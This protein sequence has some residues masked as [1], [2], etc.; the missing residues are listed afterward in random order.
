M[1]E[2]LNQCDEELRS[3]GVDYESMSEKIDDIHKA[4]YGNGQPGMLHRLTVVETTQSN[5][6]GARGNAHD[7]TVVFL[8]VGMLLVSLASIIVAIV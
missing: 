1:N 5:C 4:I 7:R 3:S 8:S 6:P 2:T